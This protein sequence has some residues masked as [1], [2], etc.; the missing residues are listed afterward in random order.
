MLSLFI[1][2]ASETFLR[3]MEY[4]LK[5]YFHSTSY[6]YTYILST[7]LISFAPV[8]AEKRHILAGIIETRVVATDFARLAEHPVLGK[9][10]KTH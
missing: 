3:N 2:H 9:L 5:E 6:S 7:H 4:I 10:R 1:L 8:A